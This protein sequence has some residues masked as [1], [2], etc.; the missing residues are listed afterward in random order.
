[1]TVDTSDWFNTAPIGG[2]AYVFSGGSSVIAGGSWLSPIIGIGGFQSLM[3]NIESSAA[4][5]WN[6][7]LQWWADSGGTI[8]TGQSITVNKNTLSPTLFVVPIQGGFFTLHVL[9]T[10]GVT[11]TP[12][13]LVTGLTNYATTVTALPPT[14]LISVQ[15]VAIPATTDQ[16]YIPGSMIPGHMRAWGQV[17]N[18][19]CEVDIQRWNGTAWV[20]SDLEAQASP[21][22]PNRFDFVAPVD[23]WRVMLDNTGAGAGTG[24]LSVVGP[25]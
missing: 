1:M 7:T 16:T 9:N 15:S 11:I 21:G 19:S 14:Q 17:N 25:F 5:P 13:F 22:L 10:S 23:D 4:Q 18:Q 2:A 24:F 12:A 8:A 6:V 20:F 3:F